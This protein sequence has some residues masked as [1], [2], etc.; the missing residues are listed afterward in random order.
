MALILN[1]ECFISTLDIDLFHVLESLV[2]QH[3][4]NVLHVP[5][6]G[7]FHNFTCN[8]W[9]LFEDF[10]SKE[11]LAQRNCLNISSCKVDELWLLVEAD[12]V[13]A[14]LWV[15]LALNANNELLLAESLGHHVV[16]N[17]DHSL[18]DEVHICNFIFFVKDQLVVLSVLEF[19]WL[20]SKANVV[21]E[22]RVDIFI[23][24]EENS[25]AE[26]DVI[27]QVMQHNISFYYSWTL[28]EELVVFCDRG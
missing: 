22:L 5:V 8:F 18:L 1:V 3:I 6:L 11:P 16:S 12:I 17:S 28:V 15:L 27:E 20:Q 23:R 7:T 24:I 4:L 19:R 26:D 25:V 13:S 2:H 21:N 14:Y 9:V 10:T